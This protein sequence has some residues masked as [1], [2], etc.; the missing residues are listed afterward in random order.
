MTVPFILN[1]MWYG[2]QLFRSAMVD[3]IVACA[4][5]SLWRPNRMICERNRMTS[6]PL[7]LLAHPSFL[8]PASNLLPRHHQAHIKNWWK[9]RAI[10][11]L[12]WNYHNICFEIGHYYARMW[13][14][15][16]RT[17]SQFSEHNWICIFWLG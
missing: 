4:V 10:F 12:L 8:R 11:V 7:Y 3:T 13:V 1:E 15:F 16:C 9:K 14:E 17:C 6:R 2:K 5:A